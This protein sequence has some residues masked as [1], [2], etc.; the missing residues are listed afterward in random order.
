MSP[1]SQMGTAAAPTAEPQRGPAAGTASCWVD[2][3]MLGRRPK[4]KQ[5]A[6]VD[7]ELTAERTVH[8]GMTLARRTDGQVAL[9]TGAVP[10]ERVVAR[11]EQRRGVWQ[12][13]VLS[14]VEPSLDRVPVPAHPGLD[15]GHMTYPRQLLEK[16]RV[17]EDSLRR[18]RA[19]QG[20]ESP[21]A[22]VRPAP[23]EW[24]YR[25]V[26]QPATA[27]TGLGYRRPGTG[28]VVVLGDDPT[29]T[30]AVNSAWRVAT[31][32]RAYNAVGAKELVMRA[33][34][35]G[36]ALVAIV[37]SA[38]ARQLLPLAHALVNAGIAGVAAAP[39]DPRGRFRRG[40]ER[41]AGRRT[42][43]QRFGELELTVNATSFAQP[44]VAAA[45]ALYQTLAVW[46]GE[47]GHAWE[48]YAGGG[49]IALHLADRFEAVTALELDR[50]AITRG[51][52]DAAR[53]GKGNVRFVRGDART[54]PLPGDA[55]VVVVD[56]PRA[57]LS[58]ELRQALVE[59][60]VPRLLYVSCDV[61]T[62]A[63]DVADLELRAFDLVRFEP[64]DFYP[65]THHIEMLS[66]LVQRTR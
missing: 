62:W 36:E 22:P 20:R 52:A 42:V 23:S 59:A 25:S 11:L 54:S 50:G 14:V 27:R 16:Q 4:P 48:L 21:S 34:D 58:A 47:G 44:N 19:G 45:A 12:G 49:A 1:D 37:T 29:A 35:M 53:L 13:A 9:I 64:F 30:D 61:A 6:T 3:L 60:R 10:G 32:L 41:L 55:D 18:A 7:E 28:E 51:E 2:C 24:R 65:H 5:A 43:L 46:A 31:E 17:V 66:E 40:T 33:N 15:Y 38:P 56:P 63:R 26:I 57:G 39:Y 8:G